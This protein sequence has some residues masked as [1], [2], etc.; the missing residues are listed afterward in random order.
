MI[1]TIGIPPR[2]TASAAKCASAPEDTLMAGM[3][4]ISLMRLQTSFFV[5]SFLSLHS[6]FGLGR[7]KLISRAGE[8]SIQGGQEKNTQ[9]QA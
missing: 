5:I 1:S 6:F 2:V 7:W 9:N 4:P 8:P 3:M